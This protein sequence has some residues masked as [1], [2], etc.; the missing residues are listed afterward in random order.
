MFAL[1][2]LLV[3]K[4]PLSC[5]HMQGVLAYVVVRPTLAAVQLLCMLNDSWGEGEFT[6]QQGWLWCMLI[7][8]VTQVRHEMMLY[9]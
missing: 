8:N 2:L 9:L 6:F 4:R 3:H 5:E 1:W 7:N